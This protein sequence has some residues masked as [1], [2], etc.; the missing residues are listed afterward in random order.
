M[1][2]AK[3]KSEVRGLAKR[4]SQHVR[5]VVGSESCLACSERGTSPPTS[6][7]TGRRNL[8]PGHSLRSLG[9][10]TSVVATL[11]SHRSLESCRFPQVRRTGWGKGPCDWSE[12]E[13]GVRGLVSDSQ[14]VRFVVG[15][16]LPRMLGEEE[17]APYLRPYG[18]QEPSPRTLASLAGGTDLRG[19][20]PRKAGQSLRSLGGPTSVIS[21]P[22]ATV[23]W[24][25]VGSPRSEG[26]AGGKVPATGAKRKSEVRGLV[27]RHSQHVRFVVGNESCLACAERR[28]SPSTSDPARS[29]EPSPRTLHFVPLGRPTSVVSTPAKLDTRCARWGGRSP[30]RNP[31]KSRTLASL[32]G[33]TDLHGLPPQR[34]ASVNVGSPR[35]GGPAGGKVPATEAKRKSEVRGLAK[36]HRQH[37]RFVVRNGAPPVCRNGDSVIV[38]GCNCPLQTEFLCQS[39]RPFPKLPM[40]RKPS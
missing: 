3:R 35:S 2:G 4:H 33:G 20:N 17:R 24:S 21:P 5:F 1:T 13:V 19:R 29:Q 25:P 38:V 11:T 26:P 15:N 37:V 9:G 10:P 36:R 40:Q 27:K 39:L 14:H 22:Q 18:P 6:G 28:T 32:V 8:P 34:T 12:E 31:R 16:S 30:S 23:R 7:P